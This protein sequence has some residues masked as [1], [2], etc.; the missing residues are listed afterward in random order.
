MNSINKL[1]FTRFESKLFEGY[2][3][4]FELL[5]QYI[6]LCFLVLWQNE[7]Y[8]GPGRNIE[9]SFKSLK[10]VYFCKT[11][12]FDRHKIIEC[13]LIGFLVESRITSHV[14]DHDKL[15]AEL[16]DLGRDSDLEDKD[17]VKDA[18][19]ILTGTVFGRT[20]GQKNL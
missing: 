1:Y 18:F 11:K 17:F 5:S 20:F 13:G 3:R 12:I 14:R 9:M 4:F 8:I 10:L 19:N 7:I 2:E 16:N 6:S 15:F